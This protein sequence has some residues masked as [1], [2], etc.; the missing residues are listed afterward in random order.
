MMLHVKL[1]IIYYNNIH[2]KNPGSEC[3]MLQCSTVGDGVEVK[4][5]TVA[6]VQVVCILPET[7]FL[8]KEAS[9]THV[10]PTWPY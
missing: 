1:Y 5:N 4:Q 2:L 10:T 6:V 9:L 8:F 3:R 7:A